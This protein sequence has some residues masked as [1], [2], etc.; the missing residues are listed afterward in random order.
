MKGSLG[1]L[2][3]VNVL[4]V[5]EES[6]F[7]EEPLKF[8]E[9]Q[10]SEDPL[11][12]NELKECLTT[13]GRYRLGHYE[14]LHEYLGLPET[15]LGL[16]WFSNAPTLVNEGNPSSEWWVDTFSLG[17]LKLKSS[18]KPLVLR[19]QDWFC[20]PEKAAEDGAYYFGADGVDD[21]GQSIRTAMHESRKEGLQLQLMC[22]KLFPTP[23]YLRVPRSNFYLVVDQSGNIVFQQFE[24]HE[25]PSSGW[26]LDP[27]LL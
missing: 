12:I 1:L 25:L 4:V 20:P 3:L 8:H 19:W 24:R 2:C 6:F 18:H 16:S 22:H 21:Q 27:I 13:P 26:S 23:M 17:R 5:A 15:F 14:V 11:S 10:R 9:H 7:F